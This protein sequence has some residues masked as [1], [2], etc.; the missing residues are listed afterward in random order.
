MAGSDPMKRFRQKC[1]Q[2]WLHQVGTSMTRRSSI[3]AKHSTI[4]FEIEGLSAAACQFG[5]LK[6]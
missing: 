2:Y 5:P 3:V 4:D 1:R 6:L